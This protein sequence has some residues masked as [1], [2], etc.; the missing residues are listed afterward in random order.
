MTTVAHRE[1]KRIGRTIDPFVSRRGAP[2]IQGV[3][4]F[5]FFKLIS[6]YFDHKIDQFGLRLMGRM[7]KWVGAI[8]LTLVTL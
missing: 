2:H 1:N 5:A 7:M 4:D 3:G 8:A 6:E